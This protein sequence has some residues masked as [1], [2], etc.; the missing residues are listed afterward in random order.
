M[1]D[2]VARILKATAKIRRYRS[3]ESKRT[4]QAVSGKAITTQEG[5]DAQV[6][7]NII[8]NSSENNVSNSPTLPNNTTIEN[9]NNGNLSTVGV[10]WAPQPHT[11]QGAQV[12]ISKIQG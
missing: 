11:N 12:I 5:K 2:I 6:T 7:N 10:H 8:Q 9:V 1:A 3:R 4:I